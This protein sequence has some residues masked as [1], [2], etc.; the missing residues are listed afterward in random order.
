MAV[1]SV[2]II[3]KINRSVRPW[4]IFYNIPH[5]LCPIVLFLSGHDEQPAMWPSRQVQVF[6]NSSGAS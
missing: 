3:P 1:V 5:C 6:A 2:D 4:P